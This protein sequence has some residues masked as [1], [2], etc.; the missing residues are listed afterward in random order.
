MYILNVKAM[1]ILDKWPVPLY[2]V[3]GCVRDELM[4]AAS[5]DRDIC[6]SLLP[7]EV[8]SL[9]ELEGV[10][11]ELTNEP[12]LVVTL[13]VDG[14]AIEHT[15]FRNESGGDGV[16]AGVINP[17]TL[18]E[19]AFRR[20]L[21]INA[22]Y[23]E[24]G[25]NE[26]IDPTDGLIDIRDRV[27]RFI[28]SKKYGDEFQRLW[29]HGGRLF[30]LARFASKY[31]GWAIDKGTLDACQRFVP[32]VFKRGKRESFREEWCKSGWSWDYLHNLNLMGFLAN[33]GLVLPP[34][35]RFMKGFHWF[36]LWES[37]GKP[38]LSS[39]QNDWK[40]TNVEVDII[41]DLDTGSSLL[42][43]YQWITTKFKRLDRKEVA[44][45]WGKSFRLL[46]V[47]T[48]SSVA[49]QVGNGPQVMREWV[50]RVREIYSSSLLT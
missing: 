26:L 19:D 4:G 45:Y 35:D 3:G 29:E 24:W 5:K 44:L 28:S 38:P 16:R 25:S 42:E 2:L 7:R 21:T 32:L 43:E 49:L 12:H 17:S 6:S 30:R 22:I 13:W 20:D 15:T 11:C 18:E 39:F 10:K 48:Q 14:E 46:D 34:R 37:S 36:T 1:T 41:K 27:L 23:K 9:C 33:H 31:K 47:P 8:M 40:L 50:K